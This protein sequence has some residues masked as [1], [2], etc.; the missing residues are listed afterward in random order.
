MN[1]PNRLSQTRAEFTTFYPRRVSQNAIRVLCS[2]REFRRK[3]LERVPVRSTNEPRD[4]YCSTAD[5][6][7]LLLL[8]FT[9]VS[10]KSILVTEVELHPLLPSSSHRWYRTIYPAWPRILG[11]RRVLFCFSTV[12]AS[13][14][15]KWGMLLIHPGG[16]SSYLSAGMG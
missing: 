12:S 3:Q 6:S 9:T 16:E 10:P 4:S 11:T 5:S 13:F 7:R 14:I 8:A 1:F 2:K 15:N